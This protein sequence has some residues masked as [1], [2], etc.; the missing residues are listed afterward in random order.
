MAAFIMGYQMYKQYPVEKD[1]P[2]VKPAVFTGISFLVLVLVA[3]E[4]GFQVVPW[5][6]LLVGAY[7]LPWT[8]VYL[9]IITICA[10]R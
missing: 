1:D 2:S 10:R 8:F 4:Y 6:A 5:L 9:C 3:P 7:Q